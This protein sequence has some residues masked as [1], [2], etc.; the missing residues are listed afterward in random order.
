MGKEF[1]FE[2]VTKDRVF[3]LAAGTQQEMVDWMTSLQPCTQLQAEDD[4][5]KEAEHKIKIGA[6]KHFEAFE[7]TAYYPSKYR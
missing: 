3:K 4:L 2:V 1:C 6:Q 5:F 7:Q